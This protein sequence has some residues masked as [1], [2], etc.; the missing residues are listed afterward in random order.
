MFGI[1]TRPA[2]ASEPIVRSW[3]FV[4][5]PSLTFVGWAIEITRASSSIPVA[6]YA[7]PRAVGPTC[8]YCLSSYGTSPACPAAH[9]NTQT[10]CMYCLT[11]TA[12]SVLPHMYGFTCTA[13][14]PACTAFTPGATSPACPAAHPNTQP[15]CMYCLTC[16]ALHVLPYVYCLTCTATVA[17]TCMYCFSS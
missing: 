10:T 7:Q 14:P 3:E 11:C 17:P 15:I 9:Q 6:F 5:V 16:A 2:L 12:S 1:E 8:M 13:H 4:I